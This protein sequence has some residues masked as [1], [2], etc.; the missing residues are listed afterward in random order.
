LLVVG[1]LALVSAVGAFAVGAVSAQTATPPAQ[2]TPATPPRGP[3]GG[4]PGFGLFGGG[5]IATFDAEA[6]A[7]NLTPSQLFDQLHSG[8]TL[9][10]IAQAQGVDLQTVRNAA[11][12]VRLQALKAQ[13]AQAVQAGRMSQDEA[14][15]LQQG[16]DK[17]YLNGGLGFLL[18]GP[19]FGLG[20]GRG[21]FGPRG[22]AA[23]ATPSTPAPGSSG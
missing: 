6:K 8:K 19:G 22:G 23:P 9:A 12:A 13:I 14:A 16:I 3:R 17:G 4:G 10:Q 2:T 5:S 21:F 15:W 1:A 11:N 20:G 7:L 18:G